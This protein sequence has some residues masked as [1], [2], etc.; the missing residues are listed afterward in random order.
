MDRVTQR[1]GG[2]ESKDLKWPILPMPFAP[3]TTE[4]ARGLAMTIKWRTAGRALF[5]GLDGQMLRT[6]STG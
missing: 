4:A 3:S 2:A 1:F 6:A 5:L